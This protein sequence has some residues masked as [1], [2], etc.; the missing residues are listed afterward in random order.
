MHMSTSRTKTVLFNMAAG[1]LASVLLLAVVSADAAPAAIPAKKAVAK[2][3]A[4][5]AKTPAKT[6]VKPVAQKSAQKPALKTVAQ[7]K[8]APAKIANA[9]PQKNLAQKTMAH[10][11]V[12]DATAEAAAA[13][14]QTTVAKTETKGPEKIWSVMTNVAGTRS[15]YD[16][17]DGTA[18]SSTDMLTDIS[19]KVTDTI[20][21]LSEITY[22]H[23]DKNPEGSDWGD[24]LF[25]V[26]RKGYGIT[27]SL[28]LGPN[29]FVIVPTSKGSR[30]NTNLNSIVGAGMS[31]GFAKGVLPAGVTLIG[32]LN[33]A[34]YLTQYETAADGS[35]NKQWSTRQ[36]LL[37]EYAFGNFAIGGQIAHKSSQNF[38]GQ[39]T[40][41][42]VHVEELGYKVNDNLSVAIGH[43]LDG[44]MY[45][46]NG[47]DS[48]FA[49]INE[50]D[51]TYYAGLT[52]SF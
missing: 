24:T 26:S 3:S 32:Q 5:L 38:A 43:S 36:R 50:N 40:E 39:I 52:V 25:Q 7:T 35:I 45:K 17:Q 47:V 29:A 33:L 21:V 20:S 37:Y 27:Q 8:A 13:Q 4:K 49:A 14:L 18:K 10:S 22:S 23:D 16:H 44:S 11:T 6:A 1:L 34:R 30:E 2:K 41:S 28:T 48:N 15:V 9:A 31:L 19:I 12:P 46:A 42:F 51:S